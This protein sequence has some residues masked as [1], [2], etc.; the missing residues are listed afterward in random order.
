MTNLKTL[1]DAYKLKWFGT[2]IIEI[3]TDEIKEIELIAKRL[4]K[5]FRFRFISF[6]IIPMGMV[7]L[8]EIKEDLK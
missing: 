6:V 5:A 7:K 8:T 1:K 2:Y 4:K 3:A